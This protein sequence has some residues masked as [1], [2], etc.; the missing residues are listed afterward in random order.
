MSAAPGRAQGDIAIRAYTPDD[1]AILA[2]AAEQARAASEFRGS[3]DKDGAFFLRILELSGNPLELAVD[4]DGTVAGF[5]S[6]DV[7]IT[8][9]RPDLRRQGIGRRLVEAAVAIERERGRPDVLMGLDPLDGGGRAFLEATGFAYHSTL[10]DLELPA[11]TRV[12]APAWPD[13]FRARPLEWERDK[14]PWQALFNAAFAEHATPLEVSDAMLEAPPDPDIED[15]DMIL[16]EDAAGA[17]V[18]FCATTPEREHGNVGHRGEIWTIGVLPSRQGHGLGRQLLR[19]GVLRLRSIGV[20][21]VVLSV[22]GRNARA[23]GLYDSE[24]FVRTITRDRWARPID[25]PAAGQA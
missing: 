15:A 9:V 5:V 17:L 19:W 11:G 2:A 18:G 12:A 22:N 13:G 3:S 6:P 20:R 1:R 7:K 10:W 21:D 24:G 23:L 25:P 8:W 16:V 14:R 4:S